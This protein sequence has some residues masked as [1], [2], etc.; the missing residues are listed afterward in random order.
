MAI[1]GW[2]MSTRPLRAHPSP[3]LWTM[4]AIRCKTLEIN[5]NFVKI[6][7][8]TQQVRS[9]GL[10]SRRYQETGFHVGRRTQKEGSV[11]HRSFWFVRKFGYARRRTIV[12]QGIW[13]RWRDRVH[14]QAIRKEPAKI[15]QI[16]TRFVHSNGLPVSVLQATP[17]MWGGFQ[18]SS[19]G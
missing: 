2:P 16:V 15:R 14:F 3:D 18:L 1:V 10:G 6:W 5:Y 13:K 17:Y 9:F 4:F 8:Q 19:F 12:I 11:K 7:F